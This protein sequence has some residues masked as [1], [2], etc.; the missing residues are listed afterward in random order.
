MSVKYT[1]KDILGGCIE[2]NGKLNKGTAVATSNEKNVKNL[3]E[4][5]QNPIVTQKKVPDYLY[6]AAVQGAEDLDK[7]WAKRDKD[8]AALS[9]SP[10][11]KKLA[12]TA[13]RKSAIRELPPTDEESEDST[14]SVFSVSGPTNNKSGTPI[15]PNLASRTPKENNTKQIATNKEI[16]GP[17]MILNINDERPKRILNCVETLQMALHSVDTVPTTKVV[18]LRKDLDYIFG[19]SAEPCEV[20]ASFLDV[21]LRRL[22]QVENSL[23]ND[24]GIIHANVNKLDENTKL[25][26]SKALQETNS[27]IL[28]QVGTETLDLESKVTDILDKTTDMFE[29]TKSWVSGHKTEIGVTSRQTCS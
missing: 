11:V 5:V 7:F 23:R 6:G 3:A 29:E 1:N 21:F 27:K 15:E 12:R 14:D 25:I 26:L 8:R 16:V 13:A 19:K 9:N 10:R 22:G 18:Q 28:T 20:D 17:K 2:G 24:I 4:P